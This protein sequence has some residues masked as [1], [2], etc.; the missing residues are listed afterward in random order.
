MDNFS[1]ITNEPLTLMFPYLDSRSSTRLEMNIVFHK[2]VR[3]QAHWNAHIPLYLESISN[4]RYGDFKRLMSTP[5]CDKLSLLLN[6]IHEQFGLKEFISSLIGDLLSRYG[7][8]LVLEVPFEKFQTVPGESP[9]TIICTRKTL[10]WSQT[11]KLLHIETSKGH[12][13][14]LFLMHVDESPDV[15]Y[16]I[17]KPFIESMCN[18]IPLSSYIFTMEEFQYMMLNDVYTLNCLFK[19]KTRFSIIECC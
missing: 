2:I 3:D 17:L 7:D 8:K 10:D 16:D 1:A 13:V 18:L 14:H 12:P 9:Y 15:L 6:D 5:H 11:M 4:E 19:F